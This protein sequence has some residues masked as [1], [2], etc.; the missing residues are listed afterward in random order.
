ME[1]EYDVEFDNFLLNKVGYD[2]LNM[3]C[4]G[5]FIN[6]YAA[7]S[8]REYF[9]TGFTDF[10]MHSDHNF[11]KKVSPRL[12]EKLFLLKDAKKLDNLS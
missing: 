3:I 11:L 1:T 8:L 2:K 9:A 4:M 6:A 5:L 12:Y 7:T 10:Y